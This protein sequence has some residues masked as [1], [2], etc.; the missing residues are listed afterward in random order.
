MKTVEATRGV[1]IENTNGCEKK[2]GGDKETWLVV[3]LGNPEK[4]LAHTRHNVGYD[5]L[6]DLNTKP[7]P[8]CQ[9][10]RCQFCV[11]WPNRAILIKPTTGMNTSGIGVQDGMQAVQANDTGR[12]IVIHDDM[13]FDVGQVRVKVGG[14]DGRHNGLKSIIGSV[15]G[16]F[17]RVRIGIGRPASREDVLD[18]VLGRFRKGQEQKKID[19]A[20]KLACEAVTWVIKEGKQK[21]MER[22]NRRS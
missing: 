14:G 5:V 2:G 13:D 9:G 17:A 4:E 8:W 21:A 3:G 12:L 10:H 6:D 1:V 22:F 19:D 11:N 20:R 16:D 15:G 18:F 7:E